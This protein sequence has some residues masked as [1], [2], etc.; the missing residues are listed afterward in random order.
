MCTYFEGHC[1][2]YTRTYLDQYTGPMRN[3]ILEQRKTKKS[4]ENSPAT[5][6]IDRERMQE[7]MGGWG[8]EEKKGG[9]GLGM[10]S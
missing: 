9:E 6:R 5:V 10:E 2:V 1:D 8:K 7:G 4:P 3:F